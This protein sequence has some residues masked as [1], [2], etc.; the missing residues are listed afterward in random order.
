MYRRYGMIANTIE[1]AV[2][3]KLSK[4]FFTTFGT[5]CENMDDS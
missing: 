5:L 1:T 3:A 4:L 2:K